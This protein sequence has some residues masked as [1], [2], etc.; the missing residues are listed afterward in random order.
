MQAP[1]KRALSKRALRQQ[2]ITAEGRSSARGAMG[3]YPNLKPDLLTPKAHSSNLDA[4]L[5]RRQVPRARCGA[6]GVTP[7]VSV[8]LVSCCLMW[9]SVGVSVSA[10]S[11]AG[12]KAKAKVRR[13]SASWVWV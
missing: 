5:N 12:A 7:G 10:G 13:A 4:D 3:G 8:S 11:A 6:V 9:N 1:S 2:E